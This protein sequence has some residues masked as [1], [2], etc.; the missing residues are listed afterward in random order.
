MVTP[1]RASTATP[2]CTSCSNYIHATSTSSSS[3]S[4]K[5]CLH[6]RDLVTAHYSPQ[7]SCGKYQI[8]LTPHERPDDDRMSQH[9]TCSC[10]PISTRL[11][12]VRDTYRQKCV[13]LVTKDTNAAYL[14]VQTLTARQLIHAAHA[15]P[16]Q[17]RAPSG[18]IPS[19]LAPPYTLILNRRPSLHFCSLCAPQNHCAGH[20]STRGSGN[21]LTRATPT[22][23]RSSF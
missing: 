17:P 12:F 3:P 5:D 1:S 7:T 6:Y 9:T 4:T 16:R 11:C 21:G 15:A 13:H 19:S 2:C 20:S 23:P 18:F 22:R 14:M 8:L 10:P